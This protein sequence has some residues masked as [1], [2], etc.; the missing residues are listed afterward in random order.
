MWR[1][2]TKALALAGVFALVAATP[3]TM[4]SPADR[5]FDQAMTQ[6]HRSMVAAPMTG[7]TDRDFLVMMI[8]HHQGAV[9]MCRIELR[10][11]HNAQVLG[12]CRNIIASQSAQIQEMEELLRR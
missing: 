3:M 5:A 7:D 9:E 12:L 2:P 1:F 10:Y 6:M 4:Q 11:G 8:A